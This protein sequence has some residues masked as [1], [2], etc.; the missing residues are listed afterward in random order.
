MQ[1]P[2]FRLRRELN[3]APDRLETSVLVTTALCPLED[4]IEDEIDFMCYDKTFH[5]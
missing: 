2:T 5:T 1:L 4:I 3:P